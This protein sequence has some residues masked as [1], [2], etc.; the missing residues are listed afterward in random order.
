MSA[1]ITCPGCGKNYNFKAE[2]AGK[3]VKCKCGTVMAV[4]TAPPPEDEDAIFDLAPDPE[5]EKA[6]AV[7]QTTRPAHAEGPACPSCGEAMGDGSV[8]CVNCGFNVKTGKKMKGVGAAAPVAPSQT[9]P[10]APAKAAK[11]GSRFGNVPPSLGAKK[12]APAETKSDVLKKFGILLGVLVVIVGVVFAMKYV[13]ADP[14]AGKPALDPDDET[15][16][17]ARDNFTEKEAKEWLAMDDSWMMGGW[18][19]RQS[20]A[21]IDEWYRLG[22][23]KVS[24]YGRQMALWVCI[25]LP[26]DKEKRAALFEWQ[27]KYHGEMFER[28]RTDKGQKYMV[29]KVPL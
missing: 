6:K 7:K 15:V 2:L 8:I 26:D 16:Q 29:I 27:K 1:S 3:K 13:G 17:E 10:A 11:G 18:N 22:A 24:V 4:P 28:I 21:K 5:L 14:N 25:E 23:K 9:Q 19:R 12:V 20:E